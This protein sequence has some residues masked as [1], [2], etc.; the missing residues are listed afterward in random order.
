MTPGD[1]AHLAPV[2]GGEPTVVEWRGQVGGYA[3]V[4]GADRIQFMV[5]A[6]R[7]TAIQP[8]GHADQRARELIRELVAAGLTH[9]MIAKELDKRGVK[10]GTND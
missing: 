4:I 8:M 5:P 9:Q 10:R 2:G 1:L 7:V 3:V 6:E